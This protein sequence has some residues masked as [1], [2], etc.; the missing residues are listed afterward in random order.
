MAQKI[1][2][3][4]K[5]KRFLKRNMTPT[6]AKHFAYQ[7]ISFLVSVAMIVG[8]AAYAF[9][10]SY[11]EMRLVVMEDFTITAHTGAFDTAENS[12]DSVE[13]AVKNNVDVF[14]IDVRQRPNGTLVMSHDVVALNSS[15]VELEDAFKKLKDT[16]I[17]LNLDIKETRTLESLNKLLKKYELSDRVFFTGI[18]SYQ[19]EDVSSACPDIPFYIN[20]KPSRIKIFSDD[21]QQKIIDL[22]ESTGAIGVNCNYKYASRT[23]ADLLHNNGYKLS[24]WTADTEMQMKRALI[25]RPD[26]IT[27]KNYDQLIYVMDNWKGK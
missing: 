16:S 20:C 24:I 18:E 6:W 15:G 9:T 25:C 10:K 14:E 7:V 17:T 4:E 1:S 13:Q 3:W 12:L 11:E 27:T 22:M 26:N 19:A 21:Y 5:F 2:K 8:V 23:L